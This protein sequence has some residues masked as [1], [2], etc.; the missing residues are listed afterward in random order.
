MK[1][2]RELRAAARYQLGGS[3]FSSCWLL[4]LAA[5][6]IVS[7]ALGFFNSFFIGILLMGP[8]MM[9]FYSFI[10]AICRSDRQPDM[11]KLMHGFREGRFMRAMVLG[12]LQAFYLF[13]WSLLLVIP[14]IV[15]SYSYRLAFYLALDYPEL[16]P[17]ECITL[18]R[19]LM[20][21]YKK[22]AFLLDLSFIGWFILGALCCGIG[23]LFV[24]PY[25]YTAQANFYLMLREQGEALM[26]QKAEAA[27]GGSSLPTTVE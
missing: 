3:V 2:N 19:R 20:N 21:G 13:F 6:V 24:H 17:A 25:H 1:K 4:S 11:A 27:S 18:S 15:K 23:V 22:Q 9:G 16:S 12:F 10:L 5:V 7:F 8:I 14:G 26:K